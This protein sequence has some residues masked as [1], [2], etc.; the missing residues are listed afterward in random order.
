LAKIA[1]E[2]DYELVMVTNQDGL[3]RIVFQDT[4]WPTHKFHL[5]ALKCIIRRYFLTIFSEDNAPQNQNA[6]M[7]T[8]YIDN[9]V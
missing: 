8:K 6:G 7:L 4:F 9:G 3:G 1:T 2:L 5:E